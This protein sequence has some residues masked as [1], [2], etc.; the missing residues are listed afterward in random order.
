MSAQF[1]PRSATRF[2]PEILPHPL[3]VTRW[4]P[5]VPCQPNDGPGLIYAC[6]YV[7]LMPFAV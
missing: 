4:P 3:C 7:T 5:N 1:Y 6:C 2:T